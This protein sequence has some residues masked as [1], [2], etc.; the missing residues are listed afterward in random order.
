MD[1]VRQ[2]LISVR[3]T[4]VEKMN[5][6]FEGLIS[7]SKIDQTSLSKKKNSTPSGKKLF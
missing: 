2:D 6:L 5:Q 1:K 3:N 4:E 7:V